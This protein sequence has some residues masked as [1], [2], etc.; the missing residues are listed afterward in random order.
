MNTQFI[1]DKNKGAVWKIMCDNNAF[2]GIPDSLSQAVK[3]EFDKTFELIGAH[4]QNDDNLVTLN[5]R[6]LSEFMSVLHKYN[7]AQAQQGQAQ[8]TQAQQGQAQQTQAQ[9]GQAQQTQAQQGQAIPSTYNPAE[10]TKQRQA[11]FQ[12]VLQ[13]KQT[14]FEALINTPL[15]KKIEFAD[16]MDTPIGSEMDKLLADTIALREKQLLEP[17]V[18]KK[19]F[20]ADNIK[21]G[22]N[23]FLNPREPIISTVPISNVPISN[24]PPITKSTIKKVFFEELKSD[25]PPTDV[26]LSL[27]KKKQD[28]LD[29]TLGPAAL[30]PAALG[31]AALG[32][33]ALGPAAPGP[34]ENSLI[35]ELLR[36]ILD[37]QNQI[38]DKIN[39][40]KIDIQT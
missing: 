22:E 16:K 34:S 23:I 32:P 4:T 39:K 19:W 27:L 25:I 24:V 17:P 13:D 31:P 26:F 38:L 28:P 29:A 10:L 7:T 14:E 35:I 6:V 11:L 8:Q 36:E 2:S 30:G 37:K 21:I 20:N 12:N 15:P 40:N 1:S 33:A 3:S 5:K 18:T 9:Q